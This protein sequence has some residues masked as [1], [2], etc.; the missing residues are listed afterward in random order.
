MIPPILLLLPGSGPLAVV[1]AGGETGADR[2]VE[3]ALDRRLVPPYLDRER[4][5]RH[6]VGR[7]MS[8]CG[9]DTRCLAKEL[10]AAGADL[11]LFVDVG[12]EAGAVAVLLVAATRG[13]A[14]ARAL[15]T[16]T[17]STAT[18]AVYD[19]VERTL[20]EARIPL[21]GR[22][23]IDVSPKDANVRLLLPDGELGDRLTTPIAKLAPGDYRARAR[24][25]GYG[26]EDV[27]F[28]VEVG[29]D[30]RIEL[31]LEPPHLY[32]SPWL[33]TAVGGIAVAAIVTT[34]V[35]AVT[36]S[37]KGS[38]VCIES[39]PGACADLRCE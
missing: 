23:Q 5:D 4:F 29:K 37:P 26:D 15:V 33:W 20:D 30:E 6:D 1:V 10:T 7:S 18:K 35:L 17:S 27:E 31:V 21:A 22:V 9:F 8:R 2:V 14:V 39:E 16:V 12:I 11:G 34:V 32:E 3:A 38:C 19:A 24:L 13:E 28:R 25:D 36:L